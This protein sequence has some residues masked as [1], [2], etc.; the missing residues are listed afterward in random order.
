M[1]SVICIVPTSLNK[2]NIQTIKLLI[3]SLY[4]S[5][6]QVVKVFFEIVTTND[7]ESDNLRSFFLRSEMGNKD[8]SITVCDKKLGFSEMN[9][10]VL[11]KYGDDYP[12][13]FLLVNDDMWVKE[14][15]FAEFLKGIEGNYTD[16]VAPLVI[17]ATILRAQKEVIIDSFGVEYFKSGYAKNSTDLDRETQLIT[18]SCMFVSSLL[19]KKMKRKYG[20]IFNDMFFFYLEDVEFSIRAKMIGATISKSASI[21]SYHFGSTTSGKK[22]YFTMY[23]TY[24]NI[25]WLI[26]MT[27]PTQI[28]MRNILNIL[29]VQMWVFIYSIKSFGIFLYPRA[30]IETIVCSGKLLRMRK[31]II[32]SYNKKTEFN[33][34]FSD[35]SFRTYHGIKIK[36]V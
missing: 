23:Q 31:K 27:W 15:F 28:I 19:I 1:R 35:L 10:L 25:L 8:F 3:N 7:M 29:L 16:V 5:S 24:R 2:K 22:S 14:T 9:N 6:H 13:Y 36:A 20:F 34:L 11:D 26:I 12:D 17:D 4:K 21:L 32:G 18:A 30:I 33:S